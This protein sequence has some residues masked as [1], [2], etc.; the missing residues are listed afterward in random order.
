[1][2]GIA[3]A[4][5]QQKIISGTISDNEGLPLV[6]ATVVIVGTSTG[7]SAD[8]DGN[9]S[10]GAN[11]GDV[12]NYSYV[13]Y[14]D[15]SIT[16]GVA[17]SINVTLSPD[18]ELEEVVVTAFG[19]KRNPVKLGY[20]V[21]VVENEEITENS[22]P[23]LIRS[24]A[25]KVAGV[26]V[27]FSTGVAGASNQLNIRGATTI[28]SASQPL[29][30]VDGVAYSNPQVT[31]SSQTTGGGGYESGLSTLDPND[32][33]SITVLK[34][35]AA[36]A[37]YGS[38]AVDGV[39]VI[40]TK[41]GSGG[42][43]NKKV[44]VTV[45]SGTYFENIANLPEYQNTYGNGVNG[46]Y[47][48]ANG[49]WGP[50]FDSL[51]TIPT[52]PNLLAAFPELGPTQPFEAQPDNVK[53]LFQ[54]GITLDNSVSLNYGGEDGSFSVTIS[55]LEQEGYIPFNTYERTSISAGGNFKLNN[56]I[57]VGGALSYADTEQI[58]GFFGENQFAGSA[59]SFARTLWL[60][61]AWNTSL[62]YT[63]P[64]TGASV[65]PNGGW[66][67]PLWSWEH[68]QIQT[69]SSRTVANVNLSYEF[70]D[71]ISANYRVGFNKYNLDRKQIRDLGSRALNG[72][73]GITTD[74]FLNED[75]ESTFLL[76]FDYD[77]TDDIGFTGILGN[78]ILQNKTDRHAIV[79]NTFISPDI[80]TVENNLN[81]TLSNGL[82]STQKRTVGVFGE[83]GL[84]YKD[85][86]FLNATGRNDWSSSL[87]K[88]NNSY[89]YPSISGSLIF[90]E[91]FGLDS[92]VLTFGKIRA[93]FASGGRDADAEF[94][95]RSFSVGQAFNSNPVIGNNTFFGDVNLTPE[96]TDEIEFGVDLEFFKRRIVVDF[97]LYK[98]NTTDLISPVP[99]PS[100]SGFA[101]FNT[102]IGEIENKG[103][104]VGLTLVPLQT[105][106]FKWSL[107]STFTKNKNEVLELVEGVERIQFNPNEVSHAIVGKPFGVFYGSR[108]ARD[109]N[110][111][112]L[113]NQS[114]GGIIQDLQN[115]IIGDPNPDFKMSFINTISY[116][117]LTLKGQFDWKEGGD[118]H[119]SSIVALLGRGVTK[120]TEDREKT[121]VIP[122]FYGDN[123]G[124]PIL[125][126][127]GNQIPNSVQLSMNELYFSPAG[128][129]TFGINSVD[130][131][132]VYDGT[133][134]RLREL[135]L[136]YNMPK[137]WLD[138]TPFG[139]ISITAVANNLWYF[140]PNVPK[141][142]NF[143]PEVT[144]F[145]STRLQGVEVSAAP[146]SKRY[147][148]KVNLTF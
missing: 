70:N 61:R 82:G 31:T 17:N 7:V 42:T 101:T 55:D 45:S 43:T 14:T 81:V 25:G 41:G 141:Y 107:F 128:G 21:S 78:N 77:I 67:H 36:A 86:L 122:G 87:P 35:V 2:F 44:N 33:A 97:S 29:I 62:P 112:F 71:N 11:V 66:D 5:A 15:K 60:G 118:V 108:F 51:E 88:D 12:L 113:I 127:Q 30:I 1:M 102:N 73:G 105:D 95:S 92:D 147:G 16:V 110:G 24:L 20:A 48:N 84:S 38:R 93:G 94:L 90:T 125:D 28:G 19:I 120:D 119:S 9:Y 104:E 34:S 148:F 54:T 65:I 8:F 4:L 136:S 109:D 27:N 46:N 143:D 23:D 63:H 139:K 117:N 57:T 58:G 10:I 111:N 103:V 114:G 116:K 100:S 98:K 83:I 121:F 37:L 142:T 99:V 68:D 96:F 85:F 75:I 126:T 129:N 89:F 80:F 47:V 50:R 74:E 115:G 39:I 13:G 132:A 140:A 144:S 22:E 76:N 91:A 49:S 18:N 106:N 40:T 131:A 59:S 26:N 146:T 135:S 56:G 6:G 133:V 79:A 72:L 124:D 53:N 138:K 3:S 130:E 69:E 134:Y 52:W 137:K 32:I 145:G 64:V 123:N